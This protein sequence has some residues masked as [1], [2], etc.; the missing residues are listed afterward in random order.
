MAGNKNPTFEDVWAL[1]HENSKHIKELRA[2]SKETTAQIQDLQASVNKLS[3]NLGGLSNKWGSLGEAMTV[4]SLL[5]S[6]TT[7]RHRGGYLI[8]SFTYKY[9][10]EEYE[11]D[12]LAIGKNMVVAIEAKATLKQKDVETFIKHNSLSS[13]SLCLPL[14]ASKSTG[15]WVFSV[16]AMT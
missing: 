5:R 14:R 1:I 12:G 11:V 7:S 4:A 6:S 15:R 3:K 13:L 8:P 10:G 2:E 9:E 16:P